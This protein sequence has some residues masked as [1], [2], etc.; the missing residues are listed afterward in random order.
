MGFK[1]LA[2]TVLL[3]TACDC[4]EPHRPSQSSIVALKVEIQ[5]D[6]AAVCLDGTLPAFYLWEGAE[7][8][9]FTIHHEGGGWCGSLEDC[10]TRSRGSLGSS[11]SWPNSTDFQDFVDGWGAWYLSNDEGINPLMHNW[12][13]ILFKYCDGAS[14]LGN[15]VSTVSGPR[16]E[17][18][19]F[20]GHRILRAGIK[21]MMHLGMSEASAVVVN[22][23]SAGG[24]SAYLHANEYLKALPSADVVALPDGGFF[25]PLPQYSENMRWIFNNMNATQALD[26]HCI[27]AHSGSEWE[28]GLAENAAPYILVPVF[29]LQ[30]R[31]DS[32]QRSWLGTFDP[33]IVTQ[34]G[35]NMTLK[36]RSR[37]LGTHRDNAIFI[38]SCHHHTGGWSALKAAP[39][40]FPLAE[41]VSQSEAFAAWWKERSTGSMPS[42]REWLQAE[43]FPCPQCCPCP[44]AASGGCTECCDYPS[45]SHN[46][47]SLGLQVESE[48]EV[49]V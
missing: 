13:K 25:L 49:H 22:G 15:R 47:C 35:E 5:G 19:Y 34:F 31:Y 38:D 45:S 21:T 42:T 27:A 28:C 9:R 17:A 3:V 8:K 37:V 39:A 29:A 7:S 40:S 6:P 2:V 41:A 44:C 24:L 33:V 4:L 1:Q 18:L 10:A 26:K 12:T 43:R 16:G 23:G 20:A 14:F 36:L 32:F 46:T 30:A 48:V 11:R